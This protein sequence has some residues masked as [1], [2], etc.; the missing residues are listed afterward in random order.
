MSDVPRGPDWWQDKDG[1]WYPSHVSSSEDNAETSRVPPAPMAES[2]EENEESLPEYFSRTYGWG[3]EPN[4]GEPILVIGGGST[5]DDSDPKYTTLTERAPTAVHQPVRLAFPPDLFSGSIGVIG[6]IFLVIGSFLDWATAGGSL[7][8]GVVEGIG[9][10][11]GIGTLITGGM[12][13][14]VAGLF[15][16]GQRKRWVG[17]AMIISAGVAVALSIFSIVDIASTSNNIPANLIDRFPTIDPAY[18]SNAKLD[19][20][21]GLWAVL[22]GSVISLLAGISGFKR[23]T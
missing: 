12:C 15:L 11:N 18:A 1:Q 21:L 10:S 5:S 8:T 7:T 17:L 2:N 22:G 19:F 14:F 20:D 13:A 9:D 16:S 4:D 23:H 6:A 3:E